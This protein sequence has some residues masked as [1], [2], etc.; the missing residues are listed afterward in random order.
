MPTV[1]PINLSG[2]Q[3]TVRYAYGYIDYAIDARTEIV[4]VPGPSI[5]V[6]AYFVK[7][8][9]WDSFAANTINLETVSNELSSPVFVAFD[10]FD[11]TDGV[12]STWIRSIP[13][14]GTSGDDGD[15]V[16]FGLHFVAS[17]AT[18]SDTPTVGAGYVVFTYLPL[19][20]TL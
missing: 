3:D 8:T 9:E 12:S 7:T 13:F 1:G 14:S 5:I 10:S 2:E 11:P 6:G 15:N 4:F 16:G 18:G 17:Y 19:P 20:A